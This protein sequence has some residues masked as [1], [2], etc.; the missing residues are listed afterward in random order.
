MSRSIAYG[1]ALSFWLVVGGTIISAPPTLVIDGT[2]LTVAES[3]QQDAA[4]T[5]ITFVDRTNGWAVGDRGTIWHT[6]DSGRTWALQPSGV[7][8][9]LNSVCF[10]DSQ[11]GWAAGGSSTRITAFTNSCGSRTSASSAARIDDDPAGSRARV[12]PLR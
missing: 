12:R 10:V 8:G 6:A 1:A 5:D 2:P 11:R 9:R 3:M 4:L 7:A